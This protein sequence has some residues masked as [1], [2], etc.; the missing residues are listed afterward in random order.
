MQPIFNITEYWGFFGFPKKLGEKLVWSYL[1]SFRIKK[2]GHFLFTFG[3]R[4]KEKSRICK[5][6][7][8]TTTEN[9]IDSFVL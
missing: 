3:S 9:E 8:T 7:V 6:V 5:Y 2:I 4:K 1:F